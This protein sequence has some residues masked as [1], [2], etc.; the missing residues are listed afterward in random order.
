MVFLVKATFMLTRLLLLFILCAQSDWF[1]AQESVVRWQNIRAEQSGAEKPVIL[2][3]KY[4]TCMPENIGVLK[5][6]LLSV[7]SEKTAVSKTPEIITLPLPDGSTQRFYIT[8]SSVLSPAL[9]NAFPEIRSYS[10]RGLDDPYA[11]GKLDWNVFGLHAA[12]NSARGSFYI[13]PFS[14]FSNEK[15][16]S[17]YTRDFNKNVSAPFSEEMLDVLNEQ[18]PGTSLRAQAVAGVACVGSTLLNYRLAL[19]CTH[20]YAM[21]VT[22]HT[23]PTMVQTLSKMV[24]T[25]NRV[26]GVFER[27]VAIRLILVPATTALIFTSE[28]NDPFSAN[29]NPMQLIIQSQKYIDS[30]VGYNNYDIGHTFS[31]GGGGLAQ[32]G[33]ICVKGKKAQGVTGSSKPSGDPFDIDYVAHEMG[34]Q[35]GAGH[36]FNA[37]TGNCS[38]NRKAVSATEPGSGITIMGYAGICGINNLGSNSIPYFHARSYD[39]IVNW[40]RTEPSASCFIEEST[41]NNYPVV[42]PIPSQ[43]NIPRGTPFQLKGTAFDPDGDSLTYSWEEVSPPPS[44]ANWNADVKPYFRSYAP[45]TK[46]TR[47]FPSDAVL[48]TG[49]YTGTPGEYLSSKAQKL[50]FRFTARDNRPGGGGVCTDS[51]KVNMTAAGPF[52]VS[53]PSKGGIVWGQKTQQ[54]ITWAVNGTDVSPVFCNTVDILCSLDDGTSYFTLKSST[55]NDGDEFVEL[56]ALSVTNDKCRIKI[57][58]VGNI[59]FDVSDEP[60]TISADSTVGLVNDQ[61]EGTKGWKIMPN[62]FS[63]ELLIVSEKNTGFAPLAYRLYDVTGRVVYGGKLSLQANGCYIADLSAIG[64]GIYLLELSNGA[65]TEQHRVVKE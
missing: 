15:Y 59:F 48:R 35:I 25:I 12:V 11:S 43:F 54:Q 53:I 58:S 51:T 27:E 38:G 39:E 57:Q 10:L 7:A 23:A 41:G 4:R 18:E 24:V 32:I 8:E 16:I 44:A 50:A 37:V 36:T 40:T 31:T 9:R 49:N 17:Y 3:L 45:T 21:A 34:H 2:P 5:D 6:L 30:L 42:M 47:S 62:P 65:F 56:P 19:A 20:Q 1:R 52:S 28:A 22:G 33:S 29:S 64:G 55:A 60:F 14:N 13:D 46:T 63:S 26:N 61:T